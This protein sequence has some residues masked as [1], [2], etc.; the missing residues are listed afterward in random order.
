[1]K[2]SSS[3]FEHKTFIPQKFTCQGNG[4]NPALIIEGIPEKVKSLA[5]IMDDPDAPAEI[6]Y[7]GCF[8]I[9]RLWVV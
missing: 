6:L 5:L 2:L 8:M 7:I 9:S 4:I 3:E 1:M